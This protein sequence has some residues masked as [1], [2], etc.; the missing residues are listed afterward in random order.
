LQEILRLRH[1]G[2]VAAGDPNVPVLGTT[3]EHHLAQ[4]DPEP[5]RLGTGDGRSAAA[6]CVAAVTATPGTR[7]AAT[8]G[9]SQLLLGAALLLAAVFLRRTRPV[10]P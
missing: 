1:E 8:G 5:V 9:R 6:T 2:A 4:G 7:P 3:V 10:R